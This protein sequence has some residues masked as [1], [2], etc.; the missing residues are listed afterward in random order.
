MSS[1]KG[2]KSNYN[3][4]AICNFSEQWA[5]NQF[6]YGLNIQRQTLLKKYASNSP[7]NKIWWGKCC[8]SI[9]ELNKIWGTAYLRRQKY[10][11][12]IIIILCELRWFIRDNGLIW[13]IN[14]VHSKKNLQHLEYMSFT[15][16]QLAWTE[17]VYE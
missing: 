10:N 16:T 13:Q 15:F 6:V 1:E 9:K 8:Y 14:Y 5:N 2:E 11:Q 4:T 12:K 7:N 17:Y 3:T